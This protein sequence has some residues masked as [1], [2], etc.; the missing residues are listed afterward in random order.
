[1]NSKLKFLLPI[2]GISLTSYFLYKKRRRKIFVSYHSKKEAKYKNMLKAWQKNS[3]FDLDFHDKSVG[4]SINTN[5]ESRIK[6]GITK[7]LNESNLILCIV[8][9]ET[10]QRPM[11]N[12]ELE[13]AKELNKKIL[14]VKTNNKYKTPECLLGSNIRIIKKFEKDLILKEIYKS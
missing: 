4:L 9:E 8:G 5:N 11:I 14:V 7:N 12:W 3:N 6:A 2:I 10:H 1:M 13:K